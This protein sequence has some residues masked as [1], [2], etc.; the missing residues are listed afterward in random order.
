MSDI[1]KEIER[2]N[3]IY[4]TKLSKTYDQTQPYFKK[5]NTEQVAARLKDLS[6]RTSGRALLDLGCGTGFMLTLAKPYFKELHGIDLTPSMLKIAESKFKN[7]RGRKV[8]LQTGNTESL[9]YPSGQ[10]DVVTANS[11]LH[12]LHQLLPTLKEACRVLKKG[13]IFYSEQDPNYYF[14]ES[15]MDI[16]K[17]P[18]ISKLLEAERDAV[19]KMAEKVR[20]AEKTNLSDRVIEM[21]EY[22]KAKGGFKETEIKRYFKKAGFSKID[23]EYNWFWQEGCVV[24]DLSPKAAHYFEEHLRQALPVSRAFFKYIRITAVK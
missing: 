18:G 21:A 17:L 6:S 3:I 5:E 24:R 9:P 15:M 1:K 13:G 14:W 10:F 8:V 16:E 23:Y 22:Q 7:V 19:C 20:A 2:S 12:H 11:F 4:H